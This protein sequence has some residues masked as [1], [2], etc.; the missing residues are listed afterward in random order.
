MLVGAIRTP[1]ELGGM[2]LINGQERL[3]GCLGGA[4]SPDRDFAIFLDWFQTDRLDLGALVT[5][6]YTLDQVN[7]GV[8]ALRSGWIAGRAVIEL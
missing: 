6:R 3:A 8:E 1:F 4:C 7:D 5:D 2:E